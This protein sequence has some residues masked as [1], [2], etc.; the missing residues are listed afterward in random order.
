M[1][2][3]QKLN[4]E[5]VKLLW[6]I[7]RQSSNYQVRTRAQC[8]LL[9]DSEYE[10]QELISILGV[11][12]KTIYNWKNNW[13]KN[14]LVGLYNRVGRGRKAILNSEQKEQVKRWE[15]QLQN[16]SK[17]MI[18][19]KIRQEWGITISKDTVTRVLS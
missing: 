15:N 10:V 1:Q 12:R 11:S 13:S 16:N 2:L 17:Q 9:M 5:T 18:I 3:S 14:K 7:Y 8:I 19:G 6:R 4:P